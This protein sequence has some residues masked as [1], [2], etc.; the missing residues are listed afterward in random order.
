MHARDNGSPFGHVLAP[1]GELG[2]HGAGDIGQVDQPLFTQPE[3]LGAQLV[4]ADAVP[5][6]V[7]HLLEHVFVVGA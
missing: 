1:G 7:Q 4:A 3:Q 6:L 2:D 5:K